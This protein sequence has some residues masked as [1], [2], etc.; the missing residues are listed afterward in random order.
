MS[1]LVVK[2]FDLIES[3]MSETLVVEFV[4]DLVPVL[5]WGLESYKLSWLAS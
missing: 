4:E 3:T 1:Y 5:A 2:W